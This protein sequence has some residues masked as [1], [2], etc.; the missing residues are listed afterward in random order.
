MTGTRTFL[1]EVGCEEIPA[2]MLPGALDDLARRLLVELGGPEGLGGEALLPAPLGGP[3]RLIAFITSIRERE[4]DRVVQVTGPPASAAF[5]PQGRPTKAALGFARAQGIDPERLLRVKG[6]KG[7]VVAARKEV[8]GRAAAAVLAE[9]CPRVLSAMRF[10]KMMKWGDQGKIFVRPVHWIVALLDGD[11]VP[12]EFLGIRSGRSSRGHRFLAPGPHDV[13]AARD[14]ERVLRDK[15]KVE[16][17]VARRRETIEARRDEAAAAQGWRARSDPAL[18]EELT[19]LV[20]WPGVV[21]GRFPEE[22]LEIPEPVIVTAMRHHQKYFPAETAGGRLAAGF[23]AVINQ[24]S[25]PDG[26]IRK[27]NEWVLKARLSDARFFWREDR[28]K[29]LQQRLPDLARVSFHEKLG[30]SLERSRRLEALAGVLAGWAG[31]GPADA[32]AAREAARISKADLVTGMVGEFPELQGVMGGIYARAEGLPEATA[33]AIEEQY[34][35]ASPLGARPATPAGAVLALADKLDLLSGCFAAG[36]IPRGSADPYGLRRAALGVCLLCVH[37]PLA[38]ARGRIPLRRA[39]HEALDGYARQGVAVEH[40][41]DVA[42]ALHDFIGQRLRFLMEEAGSRL[43]T[44]RA[45][46][47]AGADDLHDAWLRARALTELRGPAHEQDFLALASSAKRIRNILAQARERGDDPD[48]A[49][50]EAARLADAEEKELHRA[51]ARVGEAIEEPIARRDHASALRAI[52]SLRPHVDRFFD[53][54]LVMAPDAG[55]R[56]N[57]LALLQGLSRLLSRVAE[58]SE[59]VVEGESSERSA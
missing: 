16:A 55:Q 21:A 7:E 28:K 58:F 10:P 15:G 3:R 20:E 52:A 50:V 12:F 46:L 59:I 26:A 37:E 54:V 29:S 56:R 40:P 23:L 24:D 13:P 32:A 31:L 11:V 19:F 45:V 43:D 44:A 38:S 22:F 8:P 30:S 25:D 18:L 27:G 48:G 42:S 49:P 14:H 33:K 39:L 5:D 53:K 57:R 41:G 17:S 6:D 47:A 36:L 35:P 9:A 51:V 2:A 4:D 34:L 1:L